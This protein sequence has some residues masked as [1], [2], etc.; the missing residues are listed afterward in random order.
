[1]MLELGLTDAVSFNKG[2]YKG[3]E[4]VAMA[5]YRGHVSKK[6]SGL[7]LQSELIPSG[8]EA[9]QIEG[10][11]IGHVTSATVSS[12]SSRVIALAYLK[13]G[14]FEPGTKVE[15]LTKDQRIDA[16]VTSLPF[17]AGKAK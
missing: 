2:C 15:V 11:E 5:T 6:L 8:G 16:E 9:V 13:Y 4:A 7:I 17:Y 1:M 14:H 3:Q 12:T 10:K